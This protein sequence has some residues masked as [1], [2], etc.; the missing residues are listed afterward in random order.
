[1]HV[2]GIAWVGTRT[3][4]WSETVEMFEQRLGLRPTARPTH[5]SWNPPST[6]RTSP[7]V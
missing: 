6:V 5:V 2:Q 7:V 1:M 4:R 3:D